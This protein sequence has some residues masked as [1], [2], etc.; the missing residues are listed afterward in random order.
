M[1]FI[2]K[3]E[4]MT[5]VIRYENGMKLIYERDKEIEGVA[6]DFYFRAGSLNDPKGKQGLAHLTEH[7]LCSLSN[8]IYD[9]RFLT[10][11]LTQKY[12]YKNARTNNFLLSF[13]TICNK[14][15]FE[16]CVEEMTASFTGFVKT[17]EFEEE[18]KIVLQEVATRL[19]NKNANQSCWLSVSN[20]RVEPEYRNLLQENTIGSKESVKKLTFQ[21]VCKFVD[22]YFGLNN[23]VISIVGNISLKEVKKCVEKYVFTRIKAVSKIGFNYNDAQKIKQGLDLRE[24]P[25]EKQKALIEVLWPY[26][27][28]LQFISRKESFMRG[29]IN[30]VLASMVF[31]KF[32]TDNSSCYSVNFFLTKFLKEKRVEFVVECGHENVLLNFKI[33]LE[34]L[35]ELKEKGLD[36]EVFEKI[37][38]RNCACINIDRQTLTRRKDGLYNQLSVFNEVKPKKE[39]KKISLKF[40]KEIPFEEYNEFLRK[41]L[42]GRPNLILL[43]TGDQSRKI[44]KNKLD[45]ILKK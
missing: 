25:W 33:L 24:R 4:S 21:D 7:C 36:R 37:K 1:I 43:T 30:N 28:S 3:G 20:I 8:K 32:R 34:F 41:A 15:Q 10:D 35:K 12:Y 9:R 5:K 39:S 42:K 16:E 22:D 27:N 13:N 11:T 45:E 19:G 17:E 31:K 18:K 26:D 40:Y 29:V 23:L 44:H 14:S 38:E 6:I 2:R